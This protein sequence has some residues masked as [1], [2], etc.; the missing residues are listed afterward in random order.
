MLY[1]DKV[2]LRLP[3]EADA[4]IKP[5]SGG[6]LYIHLGHADGSEG[7]DGLCARCH[8]RGVRVTMEPTVQPWGLRE[9]EVED[10]DGPRFRFAA[11][12]RP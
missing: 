3:L 8:A 9:F 10:P 4:E 12:A 5:S 2:T 6:Y 1:Q 7:M 11:D